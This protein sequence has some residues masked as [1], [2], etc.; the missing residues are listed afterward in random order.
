VIHE[1]DFAMNPSL[2]GTRQ[3]RRA[4]LLGDVLEL[5]AEEPLDASGRSRTHSVV[6]RRALEPAGQP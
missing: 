4:T 1:V 6:W 5:V 2:A 3:V